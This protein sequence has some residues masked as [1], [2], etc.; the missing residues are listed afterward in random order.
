MT[1]LTVSQQSFLG[2]TSADVGPIDKWERV[3]WEEK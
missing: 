2:A 1:E 3:E